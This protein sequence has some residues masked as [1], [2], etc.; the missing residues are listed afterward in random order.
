MRFQTE[1]DPHGGELLRTFLEAMSRDPGTAQGG[2]VAYLQLDSAQRDAWISCVERV[3][4][5]PGS[6][7]GLGVLALFGAETDAKTIEAYEKVGITRCIFLVPDAGPDVVLPELD[8][9]AGLV[10]G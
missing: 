1:P 9:L 2:V 7:I 5:K 10:L 3:L 8:R 4:R 6:A